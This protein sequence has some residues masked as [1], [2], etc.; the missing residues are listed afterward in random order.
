MLRL[1]LLLVCAG[2]FLTAA[3][4]PTGGAAT[5]LG[6][7][8][9]WERVVTT[10]DRVLFIRTD[11][12]THR[13]ICRRGSMRMTWTLSDDRIQE[14]RAV[15]AEEMLT[16]EKVFQDEED[17]RQS[18]RLAQRAKSTEAAGAGTRKVMT[19]SVQNRQ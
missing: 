15:T 3:D 7:D 9:G 18:S 6:P 8:D 19:A 5:G 17:A 16:E 2:S 14:R 11:P 10:E 4:A 13:Q 1:L 12:I